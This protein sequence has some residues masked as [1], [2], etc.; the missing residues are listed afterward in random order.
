MNTPANGVLRK[1]DPCG[2]GRPATKTAPARTTPGQAPHDATECA[3]AANS[4]RCANAWATQDALERGAARQPLVAG[5]E[6]P[7]DALASRGTA[8][9]AAACPIEPAVPGAAADAIGAPVAIGRTRHRIAAA[10]PPKALTGRHAR[11]LPTGQVRVVRAADQ[12][13]R[14]RPQHPGIAPATILGARQNLGP[15]AN[16]VSTNGK[17][18][19][20]RR[21]NEAPS[22]PEYAP[23]GVRPGQPPDQIVKSLLVH[24]SSS[25][26]RVA[27]APHLQGPS[28]SFPFGSAWSFRAKRGVSPAHD[29]QA[30][31]LQPHAHRPTF[32]QYPEQHSGHVS[33]QLHESEQYPPVPA[34]GASQ[35]LGFEQ[36]PA[37]PG[38][39]GDDAQHTN[40][41]LQGCSV[42]VAHPH[43][44]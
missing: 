38:V 9:P 35:S 4:P 24:R 29:R 21:P 2:R 14:T 10:Y 17:S 34:H 18:G 8:T 23:P 33:P 11:P 27:A 31:I 12:P 6:R 30:G 39:P 19:D 13:A 15:A 25:K 36:T 5:V 42:P 28:G 7:G 26:H 43:P 40:P 16:R 37:P 32:P 41:L 3:L 20:N 22:A 1:N 44:I